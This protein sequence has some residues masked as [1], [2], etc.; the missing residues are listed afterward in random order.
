[1]PEALGLFYLFGI[2]ANQNQEKA[3]IYFQMAAE[4]NLAPAQ[5]IYDER[6]TGIESLDY[7]QKSASQGYIPSLIALGDRYYFRNKPELAIEFYLD[8]LK[9]KNLDF[10]YPRE[11]LGLERNI[12]KCKKQ[13]FVQKHRSLAKEANK[14]VLLDKDFFS[15]INCVKANLS[16]DQM[17]RL[18]F[19]REFI[20]NSKDQPLYLEISSLTYD[21][22]ILIRDA[23]LNNPKIAIIC[24]LLDGYQLDESFYNLGFP[25]P[26][27]KKVR[28]DKKKN[29]HYGFY[30]LG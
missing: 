30:L 5:F 4:K 23:I 19:I 27:L 15:K 8:A 13:I 14:N 20:K 1:M 16:D 17:E 2:G 26:F 29:G 10:F 12:E 11:R 9:Q 22:A 21:E 25:S 3:K 28:L 24:P 7:F 18:S 6:I